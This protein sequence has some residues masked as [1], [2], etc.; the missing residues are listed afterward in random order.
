MNFDDDMQ[1]FVHLFLS[2][3]CVDS[4]ILLYMLYISVHLYV[5]VID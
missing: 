1:Y 4:I 2:I 3:K 5:I